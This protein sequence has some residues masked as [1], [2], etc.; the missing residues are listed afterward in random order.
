MPTGISFLSQKLREEGLEVITASSVKSRPFRLLDMVFQ[1][2]QNSG[3]VD[4]VLIDTYSTSN[5]WYAY[6]VGRI[7]QKLSLKYIPILHGG[8][9]PRRLGR[10]PEVSDR[11]FENAYMNVAPSLYLMDVFQKAGYQNLRYIPNSISLEDYPFKEQVSLR[12]KLLW[13]RAFDEIY[14]PMLGIKVL[15]LLLRTYPDAE[16]CMVGPDK[17]GSGEVCREY[18]RTNNLPVSFPGRLQKEEWLDLSS[19]FDLFIN[20][21]NIDNTPLSVVE[22]MAL[23]LV[24]VS[25]RV[26]GLPYL[27][28]DGKEGLLTASGD[29]GEMANAVEEIMKNPFR[30]EGMALAARKKA[31]GFSWKRMKGEWLELLS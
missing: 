25:T 12:P 4:Y 22:A 13:V 1:V 3:S 7:C 2:L 11:L 26:G 19:S 20:T 18:C 8:D 14:N 17:D 23:G 5:F 9:L 15:Q 6:T 10:S 21:S 27:V 16:L 30:A 29:V 28:E 31:E 24:V